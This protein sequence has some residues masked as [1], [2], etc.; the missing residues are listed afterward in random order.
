MMQKNNGLRPLKMMLEKPAT[1]GW[2][3][4]QSETVRRVSRLDADGT[5]W[6]FAA[7][8]PESYV[9]PTAQLIGGMILGP[10]CYVGPF[11]VIRLDEKSG[12][13]PLIV[14]ADSNIQDCAVVHSNTVSIGERVIVAHQSI[15]HGAVIEDDAALYIQAVVDGGGT[16]IGRGSFLDQGSYVGKGIRVPA[17]RYVAPGRK[18]LSQE[19]AD[20]LP[21][22]PGKVKEIRNHVMELN[23]GHVSRY[24]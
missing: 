13:E 11:A 2:L 5:L 8:D 23:R 15:V 4:E 24:R 3:A 14:G 18:I 7:V 20:A 12:L 16:V 21:E 1:E 6:Q 22:V 17:G 10:R 19:E 9:D